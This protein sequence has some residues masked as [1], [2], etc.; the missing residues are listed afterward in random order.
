MGISRPNVKPGKL[1]Y[2]DPYL[3]NGD[4]AFPAIG[5]QYNI[6]ISQVISRD[7]PCEGRSD[8][9]RAGPFT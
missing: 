1:P 5:E 4:T 6:I 9:G 7:G 2:G 3:L 8:V